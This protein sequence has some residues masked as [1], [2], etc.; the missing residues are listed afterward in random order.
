M[1]ATENGKHI[2]FLKIVENQSGFSTLVVC[3]VFPIRV[4]QFVE[5]QTFSLSRE[6]AL[7]VWLLSVKESPESGTGNQE[8]ER[9]VHE[10]GAG[11]THVH[12]ETKTEADERSPGTWRTKLSRYWG[13]GRQD[14]GGGSGTA[15]EG[16]GDE[17]ASERRRTKEE[18]WRDTVAA[19]GEVD[20]SEVSE[21]GVHRKD[22]EVCQK[23]FGHVKAQPQKGRAVERKGLAETGLCVGTTADEPL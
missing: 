9:R 7:R 2:Y 6:N 17:G 3:G 13:L 4:V 15:G 16:A 8:E 23:S 22:S 12:D 21:V 20:H 5:P 18:G 11:K 19:E 1:R 14:L 10:Q